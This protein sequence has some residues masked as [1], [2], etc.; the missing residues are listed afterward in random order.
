MYNLETK[1]VRIFVCVYFIHHIPVVLKPLSSLINI[2]FKSLHEFI[3]C[4][5][6]DLVH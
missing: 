1:L 6:S 4:S 3:N 5:F 2:Y